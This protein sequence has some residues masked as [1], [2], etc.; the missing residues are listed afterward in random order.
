LYWLASLTTD[1]KFRIGD[2]ADINAPNGSYQGVRLRLGFRRLYFENKNDYFLSGNMLF[3][4]AGY[5]L[6][7]FNTLN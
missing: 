5:N 6:H 1:I 3:F 4:S 2:A 7:I